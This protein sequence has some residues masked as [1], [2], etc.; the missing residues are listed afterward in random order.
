[1]AWYLSIPAFW[2]RLCGTSTHHGMPPNN[3]VRDN[4][5]KLFRVH[6]KQ[7][8]VA[9]FADDALERPEHNANDRHRASLGDDSLGAAP[10]DLSTEGAHRVGHR[11]P[12][13]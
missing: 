12:L 8:P 13:G 3:V 6:R 1:M 7:D 9:D 11:A 10:F 2:P 4:R 5:F